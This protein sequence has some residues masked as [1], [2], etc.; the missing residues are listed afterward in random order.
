MD[1]GAIEICRALN[2][3]RYESV[4]VL[5]R[6]CR[7]QKFLNGLRFYREFIGQIESFSI[8]RE[9]VKKLLR[10]IPESSMDQ[11]CTNFCRERKSKGLDR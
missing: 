7:R 2:L 6:I 10:Q 1:R 9:A 4:E 11:N 3:D 5:S 8:D